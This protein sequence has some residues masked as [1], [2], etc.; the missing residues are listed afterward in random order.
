MTTHGMQHLE[1]GVQRLEVVVI[2]YIN[3]LLM[4]CMEGNND[5][6]TLVKTAKLLL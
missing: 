5:A 3:L 6:S 1:E 4:E 2:H